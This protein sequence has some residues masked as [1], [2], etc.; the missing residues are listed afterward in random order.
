MT[1][2]AYAAAA[3]PLIPAYAVDRG[4]VHGLVDRWG[5]AVADGLMIPVLLAEA[6]AVAGMMVV[7]RAAGDEAEVAEMGT[8]CS[9]RTTTAAAY[10]PI[11]KAGSDTVPSK[12]MTSS[13][14]LICSA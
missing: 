14:G 13:E 2:I 4:V 9:P 1:A 7:D 10:L 12:L 3:H 8:T 6:A 11:V 5:G